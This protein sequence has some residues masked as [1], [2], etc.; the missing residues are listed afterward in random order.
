[1]LLACGVLTDVDEHAFEQ[2]CEAY[3]ELR[4]LRDDIA[5][6][7]RTQEVETQSGSIVEKARPQ[8]AMYADADRRFRAWCSEFGLTP[9][10]RSRLSVEK[11]KPT[12]PAEAFFGS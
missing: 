9:S 6:K 11:P 7:G 5:D 4:E 8:V 1:M 12:D 10:A 2:C 3:A